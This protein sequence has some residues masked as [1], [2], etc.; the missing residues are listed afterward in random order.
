MS[1]KGRQFWNGKLV[2]VTGASSGIGEALVRHLDPLGARLVL[3]ARREGRLEAVRAS[4]SHPDR[5]RVLPLDMTDTGA[6]PEAVAAVEG[7]GGL[8]VLVH[9]AGISQ[10]SRALETDIEVDRRLMEVNYLGPVALTKAALPGMIERGG[11]RL[12]VVSSLVGRMAT[13][14]R[15]GYSASKHA[16][17][18]F[19]EALRAETHDSGIRITLA[20]PGFVRTEISLNALTADGS[21]QGTMDRGQEEGMAPEECARRIARAAERGKAEVWIGGKEVWAVYLARFFPGLYRYLVRRLE[22]T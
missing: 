8:D 4:L 20:C 16:L 19:F 10:R 11:G 3:S 17:H 7:D 21:P 18:G 14:V 5:H 12:V 15:S 13:P 22:V 1:A 2:W 6:F 9:N